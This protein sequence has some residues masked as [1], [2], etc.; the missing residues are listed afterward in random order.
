MA[1]LRQQIPAVVEVLQKIE[2]R[3]KRNL[4][5]NANTGKKRTPVGDYVYTTIYKQ[6]NRLQSRTIDPFCGGNPPDRGDTTPRNEPG[7]GREQSRNTPLGG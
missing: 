4:D 6:K 5:S 3:Y 2:Q 1:K 7:T